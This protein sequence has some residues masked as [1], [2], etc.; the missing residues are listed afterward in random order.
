MSRKNMPAMT[1]AEVEYLIES[2]YRGEAQTLT[3]GAEENL[4]KLS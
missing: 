2:H 3:V 1:P 4:L